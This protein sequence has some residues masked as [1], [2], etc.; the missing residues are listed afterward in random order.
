MF[1]KGDSAPSHCLA[2]FFVCLPS[3]ADFLQAEK[4]KDLSCLVCP[5]G[6]QPCDFCYLLSLKGENKMP[7]DASNKDNFFLLV[8][9]ALVAV[10][11]AELLLLSV[12][13]G[14]T[15]IGV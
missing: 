3:T 14:T 15:G 10:P 4:L 11:V 8:I 7:V 9:Q 6:R 2:W 1:E 5:E 12:T 13:E